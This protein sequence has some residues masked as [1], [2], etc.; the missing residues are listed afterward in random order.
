MNSSEMQQD[1]SLSHNL[2]DIKFQIF[3]HLNLNLLFL[4]VL[5][6]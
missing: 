3:M 6:R 2:I 5:F 4:K 1:S